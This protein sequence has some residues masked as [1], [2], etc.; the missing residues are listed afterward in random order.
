MQCKAPVGIKCEGG[1]GALAVNSE[2]S[3]ECA[4]GYEPAEEANQDSRM[5]EVQ[6]EG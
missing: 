4:G 6:V 5:G 2:P 1:A 3:D